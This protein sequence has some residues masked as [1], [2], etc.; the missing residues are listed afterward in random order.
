M[1]Q[2]LV[3][4]SVKV[5]LFFFIIIISVYFAFKIYKGKQCAFKFFNV[6]NCL[7]VSNLNVAH[8]YTH[9]F[10][11]ICMS[12]NFVSFVLKLIKIGSQEDAFCCFHH[13]F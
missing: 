4:E 12:I 7:G 2:N 1:F 9:V 10:Y 6:L 3:V 13:L 8:T 11:S 5:F